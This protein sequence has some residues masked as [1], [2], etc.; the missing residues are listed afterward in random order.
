M[1][2]SHSHRFAATP[3]GVAAMLADPAFVQRRGAASGT[4]EPDVEVE[5]TAEDGFTVAIRQQVPSDTIPAEFR[6][7]VG[8]RLSVRYTEVWEPPSG[9]DRTG[10]FAVE[11]V[12]A[13]GH[14][15]G[16]LALVPDGEGSRFVATGAITVR[17][18]L[19]GAMIE[20]AVK[21]AVVKGLEAELVVADAWL[22]GD[23]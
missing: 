20:A 16:S 13:P 18:P 3:D 22:A 8:S 2:F 11:I 12:G 9:E 19:V 15:A 6:S 7:F 5:G 1:N 21:D 10:T 17:V 23:R 4:G 14:A